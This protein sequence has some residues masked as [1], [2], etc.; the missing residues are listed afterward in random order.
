MAPL[1]ISHRPLSIDSR[2]TSMSSNSRG[3][4]TAACN[5]DSNGSADS[6]F[7]LPMRNCSQKNSC[8]STPDSPS[9]HSSS[10][11]LVPTSNKGESKITSVTSPESE[12]ML[13][14][15]YNGLPLELETSF[16]RTP[17]SNAKEY[18]DIGVRTKAGRIANKAYGLTNSI[19][20]RLSGSKSTQPL[21]DG[22]T[23]DLT[24]PIT[25]MTPLRFVS[26]EVDS[27]GC[28]TGPLPPTPSDAE[29]TSPCTP[30][31]GLGSNGLSLNPAALRPP[32]LQF[33]PSSS[34]NGQ[35]AIGSSSN[36]YTIQTA[37]ESPSNEISV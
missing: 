25:E 16:T 8:I 32:P 7:N 6:G 5:A 29:T 4:R 14:G 36:A 15:G 26:H 3:S 1:P 13:R 18:S 24:S 35:K 11:Y 23:S 37:S 20:G 33:I 19:G 28:P 21:L 12:P 9:G 34:G 10:D 17:K 22:A 31:D 27:D 30:E 2:D